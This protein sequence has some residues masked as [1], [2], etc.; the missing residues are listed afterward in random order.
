MAL[1]TQANLEAW[2]HL[3]SDI[4][5]EVDSPL[6]QKFAEREARRL[7]DTDEYDDIRDN[8]ASG[9]DEYDRLAQAEALLAF[10]SYVGNRGG[11]RLSDKGGLVRDLGIINQQQTIRQLLTQGQIEDVQSRLQAQA[12]GVLDDLITSDATVWGV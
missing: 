11:I 4:A 6:N 1:F 10:S 2:L 3:P 5:A 12:K 8:K 9:D 7:V